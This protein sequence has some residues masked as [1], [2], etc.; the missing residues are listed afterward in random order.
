MKKS[1]FLLLICSLFISTTLISQQSFSI[2]DKF[3]MANSAVNDMVVYENELIIGGS[4]TYVG[5]VNGN[6]GIVDLEGNLVPEFPFLNNRVLAIA[7]DGEGGWFVGGNF[8]KVGNQ[9]IAYLTHIH[10]DGSVDDNF[11][12]DLDGNVSMLFRHENRLFIGGMFQEIG[13]VPR[14]RFATIDISNNEVTDFFISATSGFNRNDIIDMAVYEDQL[15]LGGTFSMV[16]NFGRTILAAVNLNTGELTDWSP[17]ISGMG[18]ARI[19]TLKVNE[20]ILYAGGWFTTIDGMERTNIAAFNFENNQQLANWSP[21]PLGFVQDILIHEETAFI[22]G[23]FFTVNFQPQS[24]LVG[25]DKTNGQLLDWQ[26]FSESNVFA[27]VN[28]L[29]TD[30]QQLFVAGNFKTMKGVKKNNLAAFDLTTLEP[31]NW[32]ASSSQTASKIMISGQQLFIGG[33]FKSLGGKDRIGLAAIDLESGEATDW[34]MDIDY[35]LS[36][37]ASTVNSLLLSDGQLYVGGSFKSIDGFSRESFAHINL[38]QNFVTEFQVTFV[39]NNPFSN[40]IKEMIFAYNAIYIAGS[41]Q[42]VY[43]DTIKNL[44]ALNLNTATLIEW[45]PNPDN[46]VEDLSFKNSVLYVGGPFQTID[47]EPRDGLAAFNISIAE[48]ADFAPDIEIDCSGQ[49]GATGGGP[50]GGATG[51]MPNDT[52]IP[53]EVF[54]LIATDEELFLSGSWTHLMGEERWPLS[55]IQIPETQLTDFE[56]LAFVTDFE[57]NNNQL[58]MTGTFRKDS[59]DV[60]IKP[61]GILNLTTKELETYKLEENNAFLQRILKTDDYIFVA[62][63]VF[64]PSEDVSRRYG[65]INLDQINAVEDEFSSNLNLT[66]YPNP[67]NGLF[68]I[69]FENATPNLKLEL[70]NA[71]GQLVHV[72][73]L[74]NRLG[75]TTSMAYDFSTKGIYYARIKNEKQYV[76]KKLVVQ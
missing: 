15:I 48:L 58:Y 32:K 16:N 17:S 46:R 33:S 42:A 66:I 52:I 9:E 18:L 43:G 20:G 49:I 34:E 24:F 47:N 70:Y 8:T 28:E 76:T 62:G 39:D 67:S 3:W 71:I 41:F 75:N 14:F 59:A 6:G 10:A 53:G 54:S 11:Q 72:Q 44:G 2:D 26:P 30:G 19:L 36:P 35:G 51:G 40:S 64:K 23:D 38:A 4:F 69:T 29:A 31:V 22:A 56:E 37:F 74:E 63:D 60:D 1:I 45:A 57:L 61:I 21:K 73:T 65:V 7:D 12:F 50:C 27:G 13:G 55:S 25:V 68:Y 5:P